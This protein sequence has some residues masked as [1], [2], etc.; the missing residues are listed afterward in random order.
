MLPGSDIDMALCIRRASFGWPAIHPKSG[1]RSV[2]VSAGG[3]KYSYEMLWN[4]TGADNTQP[5]RR[6]ADFTNYPRAIPEPARGGARPTIAGMGYT[7][8]KE[9][10]KQQIENEKA[11]PPKY[12]SFRISGLG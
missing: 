11:N 12:G 7:G 2:I 5:L 10:Y 1:E 9:F 4:L 6:S 8:Q 3:Q